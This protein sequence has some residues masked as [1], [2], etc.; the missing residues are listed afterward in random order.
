MAARWACA[1]GA[2]SASLPTWLMLQS[3]AISNGSTA[4]KSP[5]SEPD[6]ME[7]FSSSISSSSAPSIVFE[8]SSSSSL[9]PM[10]RPCIDD[11]VLPL[12]RG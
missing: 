3:H 12:G 8:L 4:E 1:V 5:S 10:S 11:K 7:S 2:Q 9:S 6:G